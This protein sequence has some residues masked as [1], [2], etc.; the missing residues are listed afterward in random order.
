M[1]SVGYDMY[2]KLLEEAVLE[3]RGE[4]TRSE[5]ACTADLA[6][7][8]N[9]PEGYVSSSEQRM[10]LY[11]RMAAIRTEADADDLL[12]EIVDRYGEP[13]KPALN[14]IDIALL[15]ANA[16]AV[17]IREITQKG[18]QLRFTLAKLDL[19]AV[20]GV[21]ALP[22]YK[23]RIFFSADAKA[24]MLTLKMQGGDAAIKVCGELV[25]LYRANRASAQ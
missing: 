9:L 10:D 22:Q 2:L 17:G 11:R 13:P 18:P 5:T 25:K 6:V 19:S 23:G 14:L 8:A 20:S 12:D 4:P 3:E 24:P 7:E 16:A 21:C 1:M 15:R